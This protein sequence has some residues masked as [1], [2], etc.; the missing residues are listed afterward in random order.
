LSLFNCIC[1]SRHLAESDLVGGF[2]ESIGP[3]EGSI[4]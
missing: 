2:S 3:I 1:I 4:Y